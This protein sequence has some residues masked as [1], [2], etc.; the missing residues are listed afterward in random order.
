[1]ANANDDGAVLYQHVLVRCGEDLRHLRRFPRLLPPPPAFSHILE[2]SDAL[3]EGIVL[4][5]AQ[6][7]VGL[8]L[9]VVVLRI[10][11]AQALMCDCALVKRVETSLDVKVV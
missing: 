1:M 4:H 7:Q 11:K 2:E 3:F 6:K 10:D 9:Q 8:G 5:G